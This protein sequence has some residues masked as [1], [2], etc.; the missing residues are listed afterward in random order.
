[1][2]A[3]D[4]TGNLH[5]LE[6]GRKD[7]ILVSKLGRFGQP[8]S[9]VSEPTNPQYLNRYAYVLN[10]PIRFT[11]PSGHIICDE[12]GFCWENGKQVQ[13]KKSNE[14]G[15]GNV[16]LGYEPPA[17]PDVG[18]ED[19]ESLECQLEKEFDIDPDTAVEI[20]EFFDY[21]A[22][23]LEI[24]DGLG[25]SKYR[26]GLIW[27]MF[28][29]FIRDRN[30]PI[31]LAEKLM[32]A[33][34]VGLEA[35]LIDAGSKVIGGGAGLAAAGICASSGAGLVVAAGC[36]AT[37]AALGYAEGNV[38]LTTANDQFNQSIMFPLLHIDAI[39]LQLWGENRQRDQDQMIWDK[40]K[41]MSGGP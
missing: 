7:S 41:R 40:G 11:D 30:L 10:N 16:V 33:F 27:D 1:M 13:L 9:I 19:C 5:V 35:E 4:F 31:S 17:P 18:E 28:L 25:A 36:F 22:G 23:Y 14:F 15:K 38:L 24:Y 2:S 32:R 3:G 29:Q 6:K 34:F 12:F 20:A 37:G 39:G 21:A 26:F 8:D